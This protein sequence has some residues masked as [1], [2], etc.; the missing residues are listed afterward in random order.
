MRPRSSDYSFNRR[1]LYQ[2]ATAQG[3]AR[4]ATPFSRSLAPPRLITVLM[5]FRSLQQAPIK[6]LSIRLAAFELQWNGTVV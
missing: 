1:Y 6:R 4:V 3:G 5:H 2:G